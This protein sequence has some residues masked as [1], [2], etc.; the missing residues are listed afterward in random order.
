MV[1]V[2]FGYMDGMEILSSGLKDL[3]TVDTLCRRFKAATLVVASSTA[4][5]RQWCWGW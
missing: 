5:E 4:T 2:W 1:R 3:N